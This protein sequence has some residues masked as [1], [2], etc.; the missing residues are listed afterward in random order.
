M[1]FLVPNTNSVELFTCN[2]H[3]VQ[4]LECI[5]RIV[6]NSENPHAVAIDLLNWITVQSETGKRLKLAELLG[7]LQT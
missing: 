5:I 6:E 1:E 7:F 3:L 2:E 4:L